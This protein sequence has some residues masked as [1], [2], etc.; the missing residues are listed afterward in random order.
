MST[1]TR[2][3]KF[4]NSLDDSHSESDF[5]RIC[6]FLSIDEKFNK[7]VYLF[8]FEDNSV[9]EFNT[10]SLTLTAMEF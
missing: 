3:L 9:L 10:D 2:L 7:D 1:A 8:K 6:T 4:G 5:I